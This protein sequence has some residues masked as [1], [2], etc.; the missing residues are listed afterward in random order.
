MSGKSFDVMHTVVTLREAFRQAGLETGMSV[1]MHSS[2][3]TI[4][5]WV[6]NGAESVVQAVMDVLT[7]D[8]TL[9]MPTHTTDNTDPKYWSRPPV[10][11]EWWQQ[12]REDRKSVV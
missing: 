9:M 10:P 11:A 3:R 2:M 6:L 8:G 7:P 5:G 4:G 12:I 1:L